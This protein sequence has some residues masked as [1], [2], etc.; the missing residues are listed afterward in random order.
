[1]FRNL[2]LKFS[3]SAG[4]VRACPRQVGVCYQGGGVYYNSTVSQIWRNQ[5]YRPGDNLTRHQGTPRNLHE[6]DNQK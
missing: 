3:I 6:T 1:M 4:V 2:T 5:I